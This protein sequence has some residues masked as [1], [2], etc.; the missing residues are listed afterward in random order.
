VLR[1]GGDSV[2]RQK[3]EVIGTLD[4]APGVITVKSISLAK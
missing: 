4:Q 2:R 1:E 3:V